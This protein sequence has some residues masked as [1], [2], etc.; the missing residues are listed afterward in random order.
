MFGCSNNSISDQLLAAKRAAQNQ[1]DAHRTVLE[2]L[3]ELGD[4]ISDM[5]A[6]QQAAEVRISTLKTVTSWDV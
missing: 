5:V 2:D 6:R 4:I 1:L 3:D